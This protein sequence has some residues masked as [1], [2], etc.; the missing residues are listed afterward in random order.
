M[1]GNCLEQQLGRGNNRPYSGVAT[2]QVW[3]SSTFWACK[4][5]LLKQKYVLFKT[6][7]TDQEPQKDLTRIVDLI[8]LE[9]YFGYIFNN[10]SCRNHQFKQV[11]INVRLIT[12]L[13]RPERQLKLPQSDD[14]R[15]Y[16]GRPQWREECFHESA[17]GFQSKTTKTKILHW[18]VAASYS[19][20]VLLLVV[21]VHSITWLA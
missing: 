6:H 7:C 19:R 18:L 14:W 3:L 2:S 9:K 5:F 16:Y 21:L 13:L 20:S 12:T 1:S 10:Y 11:A 15:K 8:K 17:W 4:Y